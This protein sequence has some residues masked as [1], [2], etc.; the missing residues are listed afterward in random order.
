MKKLLS[1]LSFL[2]LTIVMH[3]QSINWVKNMEGLRNCEGNSIAL[4]AAG[5]VYTTGY[6]DSIMDFDPG[7]STYT[8]ASLGRR[9]VFVSK[10]DGSG[11][12]IWAKTFGNL[13]G[14]E[15]G[16]AIKIDG[17]GNVITT[18]IFYG[19]VDFDPGVGTYTLNS[20]YGDMFVSKLDN[21]GNF[22]W[23]KNMGGSD[24]VEGRSLS[25]DPSNNVLLTGRFKGTIDFDP[26]TNTYPITSFNG[27]GHPDLFMAKLDA[28]GNFLW[29]HGYGIFGWHESMFITNDAS[30]N[31]YM[32][33]TYAGS[34]DFDAGAGSSILSSPSH[35]NTYFLKLDIGGNFMWVKE[36][37]DSTHHSYGYSMVLDNAGNIYSTGSFSGTKDFDPGAG[38]FTMTA[39]NPVGEDSYVMK[40]DA[41]GN[42]VWARQMSGT[43]AKGFGINLDNYGN[44]VTTGVYD[45]TSDIDSGP[46]VYNLSIAP[47]SPGMY[48]M[49]THPITGGVL[50]AKI[51]GAGGW[52][53]G[54]S[55][56]TDGQNNIYTTGFFGSTGAMVDFDPGPA[57][58]TLNT[59]DRNT[60]FILKLSDNVITAHDELND[61]VSPISISPN[62]NNG[63]FN[64]STK[65]KI[66]LN[67]IDNLGQI[68][69]IIELHEGNNFQKNIQVLSSG[70][71]FISGQSDK[72]SINQ[73]I[74]VTQ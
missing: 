45:G 62:P 67:L 14:D 38:T 34:V 33:G 42:F 41:S 43:M 74:I 6:F 46:G 63:H 37:G 71:Y 49:K 23:A 48:F 54:T 69:Q 3:S 70:L 1:L 53:H 4:D 50:S 25:I 19:E 7:S 40:L 24:F 65:E 2:A 59:T 11:H 8:I 31:T 28:S 68:V 47:G 72:G 30:G 73:K 18:G 52:C 66:N 17:S 56:V 36:L 22:I 51:Y 35:N 27:N 9:D 13:W 60:N 55:I 64:I 21:N 57:T 15:T 5:N 26:G 10:L 61:K 29:A 44:V 39:P 16:N 58:F 12:F 20:N 32:T